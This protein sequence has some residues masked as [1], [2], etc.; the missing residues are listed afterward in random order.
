ML[1]A[2]IILFGLLLLV[3]KATPMYFIIDTSFKTTTSGYEVQHQMSI[4]GD[5]GDG[6]DICASYGSLATKKCS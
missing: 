3:K 1:A 5:N 6:G 4:G 2:L